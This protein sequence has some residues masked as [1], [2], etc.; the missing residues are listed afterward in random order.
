MT[1][2]NKEIK[3]YLDSAPTR[4]DDSA[5]LSFIE[6]VGMPVLPR[7]I[8]ITGTNGKG[9]SARYLALSLEKSGYQVGLFTSPHYLKINELAT[10]N[11]VEIPDEFILG[12]MHRFDNDFKTFELS[13]FEIMT[14]ISF[15]YFSEKN[16]DFVVVEVGLGGL[17]DATNIVSPILSIITNVGLDHIN[18]IGPTIED[19]ARHK[20]GII[21][22]DTPLLIGD[23]KDSALSII[24]DVAKRKN[25]E[26]IST[27]FSYEILHKSLT[28]T[29]FHYLGKDYFLGSGAAYE[30][31][32][33]ILVINA[34]EILKAM[35]IKISDNALEAAL[36]EE[37][38]PGRFSVVS[39]NPAIVVDGA[40]N[41][42]AFVSLLNDLKVTKKKITVIFAAF[43]D[44]DFEKELD[45]LSLSGA[46]IMLTT[47]DHPRAVKTFN[48]SLPFYPSHQEAIERAITSL[49]PEDLLLIVGSL[50]FAMQ[51]T[52]E[53]RGGVYET[54]A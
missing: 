18:E 1:M 27:N 32:N 7:T 12:K 51:V 36:L 26:V 34:L 43:K 4:Y 25:A 39:I 11:G 21:K 17:K 53:F 19:I 33:A 14:F 10:I 52:L 46:R 30:V 29:K 42:H 23:I 38:F 40:H 13:S 47:F 15:L 31:K 24:E 22:S 6:K 20:A 9:S 37:T 41:T 45:L 50:H 8:H 54:R 5:F 16:V 48:N 44:K 49:G 35:N 2:T 3:K 28:A